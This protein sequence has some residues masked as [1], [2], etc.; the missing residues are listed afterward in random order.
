MTEQEIR[1]GKPSGATHYI[2]DDEF[3]EYYK[4]DGDEMYGLSNGDWVR[5]FPYVLNFHKCRIKPL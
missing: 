5:L 3:F 1:E 4:I 2:Y